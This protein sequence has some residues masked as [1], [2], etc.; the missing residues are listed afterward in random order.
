M[1]REYH[2]WSETQ[3]QSISRS[4][5]Q[6]KDSTMLHGCVWFANQPVIDTHYSTKLLH[7]KETSQDIKNYTDKNRYGIPV[8]IMLTFLSTINGSCN[9]DL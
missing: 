6:Y 4:A 1:V 9:F 3:T 2:T 8:Y 5:K 7:G